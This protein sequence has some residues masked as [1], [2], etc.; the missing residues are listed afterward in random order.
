MRY[1]D[2]AWIKNLESNNDLNG[3]HVMLTEWVDERQRWRCQPVG[4]TFAGGDVCVRP[5]NLANEPPQRPP[6]NTSTPEAASANQQRTVAAA[7]LVSLMNREGE[8]RSGA[9]LLPGTREHLRHKLCQHE[10]LQAQLTLFQ[11]RSDRSA[12]LVAQDQLIARAQQRVSEHDA[13]L[14][15]LVEAW[16]LSHASLPDIWGEEDSDGDDEDLEEDL[17]EDPQFRE[18][19]ARRPARTPTRTPAM[20]AGVAAAA[21]A[22]AAI[23]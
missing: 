13:E 21:P 12:P 20:H 14:H 3:R 1:G 19:R 2:H 10:L 4:W 15:P 8:L 6:S 16:K 11:A 18:W 17:K 7:R 5:R 22:S 23:C 9:L